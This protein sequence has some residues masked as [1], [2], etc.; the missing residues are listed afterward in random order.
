MK[1]Q[2]ELDEAREALDIAEKAYQ[3]ALEIYIEARCKYAV[4][5]MNLSSNS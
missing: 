2:K 3:E 1:S 4:I 5:L